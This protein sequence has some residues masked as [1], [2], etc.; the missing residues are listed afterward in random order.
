MIRRLIYNSKFYLIKIIFIDKYIFKIIRKNDPGIYKVKNFYFIDI[1]KVGS[2][3]IKYLAAKESKRFYILK[4]L[5]KNVPI[6]PSVMP[7]R[8]LKNLKNENKIFLFIKSPDERLYSVYKEKVLFNKFLFDYSLLKLGKLKCFK[9]NIKFRY[10]FNKKS[11]FYDFCRGIIKLNNFLNC[12]NIEKQYIDKHIISQYDLVL[13]LKKN[14]PNIVDFK[15]LIYPIFKI[16]DVLKTIENNKNRLN[17]NAS[18]KMNYEYKKDIEKS[19][20]V[21]D[22]YK[23]DKDL[24]KK[25][26]TS[27]NGFIETSYEYFLKE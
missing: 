26:M 22:I 11:S 20:I 17:L 3:S 12:K 21:N 15:I 5:F 19:N 23:K 6:H 10:K 7:V 25:L 8:K 14:Y 18:K 2:S 1:P 4:K 27:K 24:Y 16:D 13:N 9:K